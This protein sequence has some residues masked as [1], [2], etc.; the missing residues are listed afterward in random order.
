METNKT[1]LSQICKDCIGN[2]VN[3]T[4]KPIAAKD[5]Y[6]VSYYKPGNIVT[7]AMSSVMGNYKTLR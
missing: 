2:N 4:K 6:C 3:C 7:K 5:G 1:T